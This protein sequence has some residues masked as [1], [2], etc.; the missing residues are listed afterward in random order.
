MPVEYVL[1]KPSAEPLRA[2]VLDPSQ[3]AVVDHPGGPLLVLAGPGTGK[4]TTLVEVV[5]DRIEHHGY[6]PEEILV[7]TF[8]RKA[9]EELRARIARRLT[10]TSAAAPAMT[11]HSFCY[12]LVREFADPESYGRPVQL[13]TAPEQDATIAE[14]VGGTGADQWPGALQP[15]LRTRGFARELQVIMAK[16]RSLGMDADDLLAAAEAAG[17]PDWEAAGRFFGQYVGA[18]ALANTI[19]YAD[20][21]FQALGIAT[22]PDHQQVLR[23]RY[24]LVVVDEYQDTDPLQVQLLTALAGD[25]RNLIVVGDPDQSIYAFRGADVSGIL[26]FPQRFA[27]RAGPAP[28]LALGATRRFGPAIL[29]ATRA[30]IGRI[31]VAGSIDRA[32]F[33]KF[34]QVRSHAA[35]PGEVVVETYA[36]P[37]AE[38]EHIALRLREAHLTGDRLPWEQMAVLVRSSAALAPLQRTLAASGVPVEVAGDEV[39]LGDEPAVRALLAALWIAERLSAGEPVDPEQAVAVLT[40]PLGRLDAPALRRLGRALRRADGDREGGPRPSRELVAAVLTHPTELPASAGHDP[41]TSEAITRTAA[42]AALLARAARQIADREAPEQVLW[43]LWTGTDWPRRLRRESEDGGEGAPRADRDLDALCALFQQAARTEEQQGHRTVEGFVREIQAQEIPGSTLAESGVRDG[44]VRLMTAHRSKGLEWALVV[45]AGVQDG[46]WPDIRYR[47]SLLQSDRLGPEGVRPP[48]SS[49]S[50]AAEERRL[51]YVACTR[52]SRTLVVTAVESGNESG[53][54]PSRFVTELIPH[55]TGPAQRR[56]VRPP[57]PMSL[58]GT[59]AELRALAESTT[60]ARVRQEAARMLATLAA[61]E[62]WATRGADPGTWWGVAELTE[63][64]EPIWDPDAPVRLSGSTVSSIV[65]CPLSWFLSHEAKGSTATTSAQGFGSIVHALAAD[66]VRQDID[67]DPVA[68][69]ASLDQVWRRLEFPARWVGD[70]EREAAHQA[71]ARFARWH[72][73]H[74]R[75]TLAAEHPFVVELE[76]DGVPTV[77]RGSMDRVELDVQGRVHVVD[78]KTTKSVPSSAAI[79]QHAQLGFYQVAVDHGA[80]AELAPDAP[81][82]GAELVQLRNAQGARNP[83]DPKVQ[84][85]GAPET[86]EPFFA[87]DQIR[88]SLGVIRTETFPATPSPTACGYCDFQQLCPAKP[89]GATVVGGGA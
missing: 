81:A 22:D 34:R 53:D 80:T 86:G 47:G 88:Q 78:L 82:G 32:T 17:R 76:L 75:T 59:V 3:Q 42:V 2:P 45:V 56:R 63:A 31:G 89:S 68:L 29:A 58:R 72:A 13:L 5:V 83:D 26:E 39:P 52:A 12:G 85:Q 25:G 8:S 65:D 84:A 49:A 74:G 7:L 48:A 55:A 77:L 37:S 33:E 61:R 60:S 73:T 15:A 62:V 20:L 27:T 10:R 40:G 44:A 69:A 54:Q 41:A 30:V 50:L 79:A 71:L 70:R 6:R 67:P 1:E 19:D 16:A 51:F 43:T 36:T 21:V 38:A 66:V 46:V 87:L 35:T 4:T 9:A 18:S 24:R 57:R 14:L 11:F 64:E 23:E 28:T